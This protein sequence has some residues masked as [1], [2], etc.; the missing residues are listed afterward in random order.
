M[1][2]DGRIAGLELV[3]L[4]LTADGG[5]IRL[6]SGHDAST[7]RVA[8]VIQPRQAAVL[9]RNGLAE[10]VQALRHGVLR[11]VRSVV[12][13]VPVVGLGLLHEVQRIVKLQMCIRDRHRSQSR[14]R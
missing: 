3:V 10:G 9:A 7:M 2:N 14:V 12:Q 4:L 5:I 6:I 13:A 11:L 1:G 8:V